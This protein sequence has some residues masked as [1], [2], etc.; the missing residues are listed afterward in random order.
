M[1]NGIVCD[2]I[3]SYLPRGSVLELK[4]KKIEPGYSGSNSYIIFD[5]KSG[6]GVMIDP[7]SDGETL[8]AEA[9]GINVKYIIL[10]HAHFDHIG[11]LEMVAEETGAPVVI[12]EDEAE[13]LIDTSYNLCRLAGEK[14]NEKAADITVKDG[15]ELN[16]GDI[17]LKFIHTP[18][19][20][21]GSMCIFA[22]DKHLITGDTL[23]RGCIGRTDLKGGNSN[24][25][26]KSVNKIAKLDENIK[27]YPG[28]G[29]VSTIGFEKMTN[30]YIL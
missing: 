22:G 19:H 25:I 17:K 14:E 10:T 30:P 9:N 8:L 15:E 12:Y 4:I 6:D 18:G 16:V 3:I 1:Q 27:I 7:G 28:H 24:D 2:K 13:A 21:K 5:E 29:E 23:F 20:T 11:A 26:L